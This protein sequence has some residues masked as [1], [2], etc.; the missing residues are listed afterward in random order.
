[1]N[2]SLQSKLTMLEVVHLGYTLSK[3]LFMAALTSLTAAFRGP[4]GHSVY[5]KHVAHAALRTLNGTA[6]ARQIQ[7]MNPSTVEMYSRFAATHGFQPIIINLPTTPGKL[8][9]MGSPEASNVLIFFHG[10]GY[11]YPAT[12]QFQWCWD[13]KERMSACQIDFAVAFLSYSLAPTAQYPVQLAEAVDLLR[14][15]THDEGKDPSKI[16]VTGDSAGAQL[17]LAV[18]SHIIHSH[19]SI[20][21]LTLSSP[22]AGLGLVSPWVTSTVAE[23]C[24]KR[25]SRRD[26]IDKAV[27]DKW[28]AYALGDAAQ[29]EFNS[30]LAAAPDWWSDVSKAVKAILVTA[31]QGEILLDDIKAFVDNLK[32]SVLQLDVV[33]LDETHDPLMLDP[34]L[35]IK[36]ESESSKLTK[37]WAIARYQ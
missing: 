24:A 21:P 36:E 25:N 29:D 8:L 2:H 30:P 5:F 16:T 26:L 31:G 34:I 14:Y 3:T 18:V 1:M 13:L 35:H 20:E 32:P 15:L 23:E 9:W 27:L 11:V 37:R 12:T 17:G 6:S 10:G 7:V 22:L 19:P 33:Y 4:S 28:A